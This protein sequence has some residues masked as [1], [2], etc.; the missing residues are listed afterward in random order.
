MSLE[1]LLKS[2]KKTQ[3]QVQT[4]IVFFTLIQSIYRRF[5]KTQIQIFQTK[6]N[7]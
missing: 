3:M 5:L 4:W 7:I 2:P 6:K 1:S